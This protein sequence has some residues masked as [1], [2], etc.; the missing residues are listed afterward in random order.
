MKNINLVKISS[1]EFLKFD[2]LVDCI[3]F[4]RVVIRFWIW[5]VIFDGRCKISCR[6]YFLVNSDLEYF[7]LGLRS[8]F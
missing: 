5:G 8:L 7:R 1:N 6:M 2:I 3:R 4:I